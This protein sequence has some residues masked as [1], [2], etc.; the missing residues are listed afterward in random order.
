MTRRGRAPAVP[1]ERK[2]RSPRPP[3]PDNCTR[4]HCW[5]FDVLPDQGHYHVREPDK[6]NVDWIRSSDGELECAQLE[7]PGA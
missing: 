4:E 3:R 1:L 5:G 2:R 6:P 7:L